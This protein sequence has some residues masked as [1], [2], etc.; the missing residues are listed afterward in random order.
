MSDTEGITYAVFHETIRNFHF[1]LC[2]MCITQSLGI[3]VIL[4]EI[5]VSRTKIHV[6]RLKY[7]HH[8][9]QL[10]LKEYHSDK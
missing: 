7:S 2:G 5:I 4:H 1:M 9:Q 10:D 8:N 6:L 3:I